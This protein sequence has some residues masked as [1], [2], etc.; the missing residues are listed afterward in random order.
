MS[1]GMGYAEY[2]VCV[3]PSAIRRTA[4]GFTRFATG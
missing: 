2:T 3:T 1:G 4:R